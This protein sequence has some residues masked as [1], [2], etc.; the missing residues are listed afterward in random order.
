MSMSRSRALGPSV[1]ATRRRA[2][3]TAVALLASAVAAIGLLAP[4]AAV[5]AGAHLPDG[6]RVVHAAHLDADVGPTGAAMV[7]VLLSFGEGAWMPAHVHGADGIYTVV[8]GAIRTLGEDGAERLYATPS[9]YVHRA[10]DML[11]V[12]NVAEAETSLVAAAFVIAPEVDLTTFVEHA[13]HAAPVDAPGPEVADV[14][15]AI[16][17]GPAGP[18]TLRQLVLELD[19]GSEAT[20][21]L[22]GHALATVLTGSLQVVVDGTATSFGPKDGWSTDEQVVV[23]AGDETARFVV[24]VLGPSRLAGAGTAGHGHR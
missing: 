21:D 13:G 8:Q 18:R 7:H 12:A 3:R 17:A 14:G 1:P 22:G 6:I 20:I 23:R 24:S 16:V 9:D 10:E 4:T 5:A 15:E 2:A 11:T 19:A